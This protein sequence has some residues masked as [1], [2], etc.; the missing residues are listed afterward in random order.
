MACKASRTFLIP[1]I[2][3]EKLGHSIKTQKKVVHITN[4][5]MD[6]FLSH[7]IRLSKSPY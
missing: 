2:D 6:A 3:I 1:T 7:G 5:V 4:D